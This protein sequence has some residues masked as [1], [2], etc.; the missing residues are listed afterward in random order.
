MTTHS[1]TPRRS[2]LQRLA[3]LSATVA[4]GGKLEAESIAP[5]VTDAWLNRVTGKHRQVFDCT[6]ANDGFGAAF[7][8]NWIDGYKQTRNA[9]DKDMSAVVVY[10]HFAMPLMLNDAMWAKYHIGEVLKLNGSTGKPATMNIFR[11]NIMGRPG[12]SYEQAMK[13][14]GVIMVACNLALTVISGMA[15]PNAG[16]TADQAKADW[17]AN[18]LP[19][20]ALAPSGVYA[21][22]RAQEKHCTYCYGG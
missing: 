22:S 3:A 4:V 21:V 14:R 6:T 11:G 19:G 15:A 5:P 17:T 8:L 13:D 9:T 16:V 20:V 7:A 12:M 1:L 18:L 2:F 10:R